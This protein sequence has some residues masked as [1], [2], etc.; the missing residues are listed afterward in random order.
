ML[1]LC[2]SL[3]SSAGK[4]PW[5][6]LAHLYDIE[7]RP[8]YNFSNGKIQQEGGECF[9][10][11]G[12]FSSGEQELHFNFSFPFDENF[13]EFLSCGIYKKAGFR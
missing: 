2:L 3:S 9:N 5:F 10:Q 1:P 13:S 4:L 12:V 8:K 7:K 6:A 11:L